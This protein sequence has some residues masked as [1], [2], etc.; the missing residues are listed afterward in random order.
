MIYTIRCSDH[1]VIAVSYFKSPFFCHHDDIRW[2]AIDPR[3][4]SSSF[5]GGLRITLHVPSWLDIGDES[6]GTI[7]FCA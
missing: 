1:P 2:E 4:R 3:A 5:F 7:N 6:P